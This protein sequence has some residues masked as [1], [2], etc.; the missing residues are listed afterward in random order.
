MDSLSNG[1]R[2]T[3]TDNLGR[4]SRAY[5]DAAHEAARVASYRSSSSLKLDFAP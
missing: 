5:D 1:G 3:L 2:A 4:L